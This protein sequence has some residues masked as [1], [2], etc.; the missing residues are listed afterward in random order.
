MQS[1][2]MHRRIAELMA[3]NPQAVI[4]KALANLRRWSAPGNPAQVPGA[5]TEWLD[6]LNRMSPAEIAGLLVSED[7]NAVR[8]RQSSPFAGVLGAREVWAIKQGH[9]PA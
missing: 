2:V 8:L 4:S 7:E 3:A 5:Y 6:L 1:L 9:E